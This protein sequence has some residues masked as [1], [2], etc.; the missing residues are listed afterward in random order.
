MLTLYPEYI[1]RALAARLNEMPAMAKEGIVF[2]AVEVKAAWS[3]YR[4]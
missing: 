2:E 3:E 4:K 1:A